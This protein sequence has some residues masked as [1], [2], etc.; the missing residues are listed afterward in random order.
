[1]FFEQFLKHLGPPPRRLLA[2]NAGRKRGPA[3]KDTNFEQNPRPAFQASS[4]KSQFLKKFWEILTPLPGGYLHG[5]LAASGAQQP[6]T[7]ILNK[8]LG[9]HSRQVAQKVNFW[10]NFEKFWH[11]SPEATCTECWPQGRPNNKRLRLV[12]CICWYET[13]TFWKNR[14]GTIVKSYILRVTSLGGVQQ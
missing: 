3:T 2:R 7:Q 14:A 12:P 10:R 6:K 9:Q 13:T 1:M 11:P 4:S 8:I 5:M